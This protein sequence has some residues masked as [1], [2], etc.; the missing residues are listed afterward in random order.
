MGGR[1]LKE[2]KPDGA[3]T[4]LARDCR[5]ASE[6]SVLNGDYWEFVVPMRTKSEG[7]M[8]ENWRAK[9]ARAKK[10]RDATRWVMLAL[11]STLHA[12]R[13]WLAWDV[14][15]TRIG[16]GEMDEGDNL[17]GSFKAIRDELTTQ[18]KL[19]KW[20]VPK[21]KGVVPRFLPDDRSPRISFRYEQNVSRAN[22]Y[23]VRVRVAPRA[24]TD[25]A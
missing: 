2:K 24:A 21:R 7:N 3:F 19:G 4:K 17:N 25:A 1:G 22:E 5:F 18:L 9:A 6:L 20:S 10:Q 12:V 15:F 8:R 14:T 13:S 16:R 23:A 11:P